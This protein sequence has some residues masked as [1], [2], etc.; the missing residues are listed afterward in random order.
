MESKL[1]FLSALSG[2]SGDETSVRKSIEQWLAPLQGTTDTLGN[3][4][5]EHEGHHMAPCRLMIS[6]HMDE[7]GFMI[8][9]ITDEGYLKFGCV[10]G[11]D[12]RVLPGKPVRVGPMAVAGV[13]GSLAVHLQSEKQRKTAV[14]VQDL[15]IDIGAA[16]RKAAMQYVSVG[17]YAVFDSPFY[18]L[19]GSRIKAKALDNRVGCYI[20]SELLHT[21]RSMDFHGVF[22]TMEEIGCVGGAAAAAAYKPDIAIILETTTAGDTADTPSDQ[23]VCELG[24]GPV[25]SFMDGG[26]IYDRSLLSLVQKVATARG[27]KF[28]IKQAVAGGNEA[29]AIQRAAAG[30]SVISISVP[31]RYIHSPACVVDITDITATQQLVAA[32][33]DALK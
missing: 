21:P 29:S 11:I 22:T 13:I 19:G 32:V 24:G 28:Q 23:R 25:I 6:A 20:L 27:I 10:G 18:R 33:I 4:H 2:V 31:C 12:P 30:C 9:H 15:Y 14:N 26:T 17:Q 5:Y 7:V 8:T 3:L 1:R 16:D